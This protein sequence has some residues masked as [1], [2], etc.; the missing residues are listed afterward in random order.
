MGQKKNLPN[1][2]QMDRSKTDR[3]YNLFLFYPKGK[4]STF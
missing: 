3:G 2:E 1:G 4:K